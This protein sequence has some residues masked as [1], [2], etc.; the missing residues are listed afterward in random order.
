MKRI[1]NSTAVAFIFIWIGFVCSISFM[2]AWLKFRAPG[3]TLELGL[4][5]G[6][7][8]FGTLNKMEWIFAIII[9][10]NLVI[11]RQNLLK[12]LNILLLLSIVIV[13]LQSFWLLPAL[14]ERANLHIEAQSV[15]SSSFAHYTY[16]I[17]EVLKFLFLT[18]FGISLLKRRRNI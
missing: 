15:S 5:V 11:S 16:I 12:G 4:G 2:E 14:F 3:M 13:A 18:V 6:K 10:L 9:L 8:V 7:L 1:K 17:L